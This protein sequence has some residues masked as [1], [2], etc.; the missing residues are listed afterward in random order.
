MPN[1]SIIKKPRRNVIKIPPMVE[2]EYTSPAFFPDL[3]TS[4]VAKRIIIGDV[5]PK[6]I[7]GKPKINM[8]AITAP[9]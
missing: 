3:S 6:K 5:L 1:S 8:A 7:S 9:V 4:L 2:I